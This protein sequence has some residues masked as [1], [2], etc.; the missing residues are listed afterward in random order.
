[1]Q[2]VGILDGARLLRRHITRLYKSVSAFCEKHDLDRIQVQ[3]HLKGQRTRVCV[4][5][6][7]AIEEATEGTVPVE[8]WKTSTLKAS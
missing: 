1:M 7:C 3:R 6:A 4:D 2:G 5:F 8:S